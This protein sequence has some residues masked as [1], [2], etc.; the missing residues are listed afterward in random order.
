MIHLEKGFIGFNSIC[1]SLPE[2]FQPAMKAFLPKWI[3]LIIYAN[4]YRLEIYSEQTELLNFAVFPD[5]R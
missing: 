1:V 4:V 5:K 2:I 3:A